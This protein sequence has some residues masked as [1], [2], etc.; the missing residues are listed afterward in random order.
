M[1]PS[2][3]AR[4]KRS[5]A[6][7]KIGAV[8]TFGETRVTKEDIVAFAA[9]FDPQPMHLD[10]EA[11]K[12]TI[13]G[14]LCASGWHSCAMLMRL[15]AEH[16]LNDR[17]S[18]GSPGIKEVRFIRPVR[19]G[20]VLSARVTCLEKRVSA[21]RPGLGLTRVLYELVDAKGEAVVSWDATQLFEADGGAAVAA[22]AP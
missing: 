11:A 17:R 6:D 1:Q 15:V 14:G 18:L 8:E 19:P 21:K 12:A 13:V 2:E 9:A 22:D 10:E 16:Y 3:T 20:D 7:I 4:P 5:F